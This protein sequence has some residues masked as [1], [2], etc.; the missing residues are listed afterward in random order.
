MPTSLSRCRAR[1]FLFGFWFGL[2]VWCAGARAQTAWSAITSGTTVNLWGVCSDGGQFVAVGEG[3]TILTS[4]DGLAWTPRV[5]GTTVWLT[6]V[7]H[8]MGHYISVGEG[9]TVLLSL[10]GVAWDN[11]TART[12]GAPTNRL[13]VVAWD[14]TEFLAYGEN[15][16]AVRISLPAALDW[17]SLHATPNSGSW[18]RGFAMGLDRLLVGGQAGISAFQTNDPFMVDRSTASVETSVLNIS[19]IVFDHDTFVAVGQAGGIIASTDTTTWTRQTSGTTANLNGLA[20]FN[21][22]L[23]AIGDGGTILSLDEH[24]AW[25][26][27]V[28]PTGQILL[29]IAASDAAA[30]I[31]G[32]GGTILRATPAAMVPAIVAQPASV[33]ETLGGA[34]SFFVRANSSLPISYQ[35]ARDGVPLTGETRAALTRLP[36]AA[37]DAGSYTVT[38]TNAAGSATSG[39][40]ALALLPAPPAVVDPSFKA[41]ASFVEALMALLPLADG[42]VL[43]ADG[44]K[45]QL[46]KLRVDGSLDPRWAV[47]TFAPAGSAT[48]PTL[49]LL[50]E[51]PDGR[52]LVGGAFAVAGVPALTTLIR[53]NADGTID[54]GFRP[55]V[56]VTSAGIVISLAL[57]ADNRILVA[58]GGTVPYRLLTDGRLDPAFRP[59]PLTPGVDAPFN[60]LRYWAITLVGATSTGKIVVGAN[61]NLGYTL[62][63][64]A[65]NYQIARYQGDGSLDAAFVPVKDTGSVSA[66]RVLSDDGV[67]YTGAGDRHHNIVVLGRVRSDGSAFPGYAP[68]SSSEIPFSACL[69]AD[70][71]CILML[72]SQPG[73]A[74]YTPLGVFDPSF[75]G[76]V[77]R[78]AA[79]EA[80]STGQVY[81]GG[82]FDLYNGKPAQRVA[83]LN[84]VPNGSVNPP[85]ILS[86][87]ADK[88]TVVYGDTITV[89][90]AVTGSA[91]LSF[92]WSGVPALAGTPIITDTSTLT[93][94]FQ[95]RAQSNT[96]HLTVRNP[97]G[98]AVAVPIVFTVLPDAPIVTSQPTRISAQSGRDL[99]VPIGRND[100][101]GGRVEFEWRKD[102]QLLP[103]MPLYQGPTLSLPHVTA[104]TAGTHTVTLR[105]ALGMAVTSAPI[106]VTIDDSSRLA[107]LSTRAFVGPGEQTLVAGF[108]VPGPDEKTVIIRA[109]GPSLA[110]LGVAGVLPDPTLT[111]F[112]GTRVYSR[113]FGPWDAND[114]GGATQRAVFAKLGAFPLDA[115]SKDTVIFATVPPGNYTVQLASASGLTGTALIEIYENDNLATRLTNLSSRAVVTPVTPAICG[116]SIQGPVPKRVLL[117]GIGPA[118]AAFGIAGALADPRISLV[119]TSGNTV[120]QNDNW[121]TN[122]NTGDLRAAM[123]A[124]GAFALPA[125]GQDAALLV[126]LAPGNYTLVLAGAAGQSGVALV[127]AYEVP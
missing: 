118:L 73:P 55:A 43:V 16:S 46:G 86:L 29:G 95:S 30:V 32:G 33:T 127:E 27:R 126:T 92:E 74:R 2:T 10:D 89:R 110:K 26:R 53:L 56:E 106:V 12:P 1:R 121:E 122:A 97:S 96:L 102:G 69:L 82:D 65:P 67:L 7:T 5:S 76:G 117:R 63:Y 62:G 14:G 58:N 57:Q 17:N 59:Q 19:G 49:G 80:A 4:P 101:A 79:I 31:V 25:T 24:S 77:G 119:D 41:D 113:D 21:N 105:N 18:A 52:V 124:A 44:K 78:P 47:M 70:G 108:S 11:L 50:V 13:N 90:A 28:S 36:L 40:A 85:K 3:G 83:R 38:V 91:D 120:A 81:V 34:A 66:L 20:A 51:Q 123:A 39:A 23:V 48:R 109:V 54:T 93:F 84:A 8:A 75:I 87:V 104:A 94:A 99:T 125:G 88:T 107:N 42:G 112:Q 22:T 116:V 60:D 98:A 64:P 61:V 72:D 37:A 115:G 15:G 103:A 71:S 100:N 45:N 35:W 68:P 111:L 114:D 6:A 9:G